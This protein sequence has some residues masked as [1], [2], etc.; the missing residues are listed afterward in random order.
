MK[1]LFSVGT[2]MAR[3]VEAQQRAQLLIKRCVAIVFLTLALGEASEAAVD[4]TG[5]WD[6][7][8]DPGGAFVLH[9]VQTG[10]SLQTIPPGLFASGTVDS[11]TGAFDLLFAPNEINPPC[12]MSALGQV[13]M[14][15]ETFTGTVELPGPSPGCNSPTCACREIGHGV[16]FGNRTCGN[17]VVDP[18]EQCDLGS[19]NGGP[20]GLPDTTFF[21]CTATCQFAASGTFCGGVGT[22]NATGMCSCGNGVVDPGEECDDGAANRTGGTCCSAD[23]QLLPSG[24]ACADDGDLCTA[25]L[26]L[27]SVDRCVHLP[28]PSGGCA[29]PTVPGGASIV[30]QR[31]NGHNRMHFKWGKGPTVQLADFG[32]PGSEVTRLCIYEQPGYFYVLDAA[33][34]PSV[35][36]AGAWT[37]TSTGWKFKSRTGA[38][39][40]ITGVTLKAGRVPSKVKVDVV[41]QGNPVFTLPFSPSAGMVV[42][43]KTSQGACWGATFLTATR[44]TAR[45]FKAKSATSP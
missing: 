32:N 13:S 8:I 28:R 33:A 40:G 27:L 9:I 17:G 20:D 44:S 15:G 25:D 23:C 37:Q 43:F 6:V 29:T 2:H 14:D 30:L 42:Q 11:A 3:R 34:S 41:A 5:D 22:C 1:R 12:G 24:T 4:M 16:L 10:N 26:C 18:G 45:E 39:D 19:W 7:T 36:G 31:Q 35:S 21:C 38:P